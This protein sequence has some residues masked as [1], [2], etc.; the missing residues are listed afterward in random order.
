MIYWVIGLFMFWMIGGVRLLDEYKD[1]PFTWRLAFLG[2]IA[3][4]L[5]W[6]I[7]LGVG[8]INGLFG[9]MR[10]DDN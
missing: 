4:A 9:M 3:L 2:L 6:P 7:I 8:I 10:G 5:L 1:D